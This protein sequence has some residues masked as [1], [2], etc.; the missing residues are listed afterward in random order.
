MMPPEPN[1]NMDK[2]LKSYAHQRRDEAGAPFELHPA[3][4]AMLQ[5]EV[6]RATPRA[7]EKLAPLDFFSL[8]SKLALAGAAVAVLVV[9]AV[10]VFSPQVP[11]STQTQPGNDGTSF[12]FAGAPASPERADA[13]LKSPAGNSKKRPIA[14]DAEIPGLIVNQGRLA[15]DEAR[16]QEK[17]AE[18]SRNIRLESE[19]TGGN[20]ITISGGAFGTIAATP[21]PERSASAD[22]LQSAPALLAEKAGAT[23][24]EIKL[25][26]SSAAPALTGGPGVA[27][28]PEEQNELARALP[29]PSETSRPANAEAPALLASFEVQQQGDQIRLVD[30]D[31]SVY[32]GK[33]ER[34]PSQQQLA[35]FSG[36]KFSN[37]AAIAK[38][39]DFASLSTGS[40]GTQQ[41][42]QQNFAV[43]SSGVTAGASNSLAPAAPVTAPQE[44]AQ[45]QPSQRQR[46][47]FRA[48]GTSR[49]LKQVVVIQGSYAE[50]AP[51]AVA[52]QPHAAQTDADMADKKEAA[53]QLPAEKIQEP[54][55]QIQG[56]A[57]IGAGPQIEIDAVAVT[58]EQLKAKAAAP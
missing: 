26:S 32:V 48:S 52:Q 44:Q 14:R 21:N 49:T 29:A 28:K 1:E 24:G 11:V 34:A 19:T 16:P 55:A 53:T 30:A 39:K 35:D 50:G 2:L 22:A 12:L 38:A 7:P 23:G 56:T 36:R 18:D 58:P 3:T 57:Q 20:G 41:L 47:F 27:G 9:C 40:T 37:L 17:S 46:Y 42:Q 6:A 33:I 4:R 8:L 5:A 51:L 15:F 45:Q 54:P 31:G 13:F 10:F 43:R 25:P